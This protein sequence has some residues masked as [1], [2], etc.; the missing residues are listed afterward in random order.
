MYPDN[1]YK[2]EYVNTRFLKKT[3]SGVL[4]FGPDLVRG[5][6]T[7]PKKSRQKLTSKTKPGRRRSQG[8][9]STAG[10]VG[11]KGLI[12]AVREGLK[13]TPPGELTFLQ[14][15]KLAGVDQR[16][17]RYYYK[18]LPDLLQATA[19]E[20]CQELRANFAAAYSRGGTPR[21]RIKRH[22]EV[23]LRE[24]GDNP[25]YHRL[26]V[27]FLITKEGADR[28]AALK[29]FK[30]TIAELELALNEARQANGFGPFDPR[31]AHVMTAALCEFLFS[32]KPVFLSLFG[33][34]AGSSAFQ[35]QYSNLIVD[36]LTGAETIA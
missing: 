32:A 16:L 22:V 13:N 19:V 11:Q 15:S 29:G 34:Q 12:A 35:N 30:Q 8:R 24:F 10:A 26:M 4:V 36:L 18:K 9:P 7:L 14:I 17:I 6:A 27:D 25:H 2:Q 33:Q 28:D 23:F 20:V 31:L 3:G 1:S 5:E 21:E